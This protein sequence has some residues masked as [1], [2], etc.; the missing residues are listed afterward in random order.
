MGD[1]A[2]SAT[3]PGCEEGA[4]F[5]STLKIVSLCYST[6]L[7]C[8]WK[9][10]HFNVP[11]SRYSTTRRLFLQV[12][13]M[14]IALYAPEILLFLAINEWISAKTLLKRVLVLHSDLAEP[15]MFDP[16]C[17]FIRRKFV[18]AQCPYVIE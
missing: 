15:G 14:V 18:S 8:I 5:R 1:P 2:I 4:N 16:M 10:L 13:W 12:S 11:T 3:V 17:H 7:I 9:T 6:L